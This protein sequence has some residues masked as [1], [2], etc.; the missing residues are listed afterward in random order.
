M[1]ELKDVTALVYD[2]GLFLVPLA[3]KLAEKCKH[4]YVT[5]PWETGFS[6]INAAIL[7]DGFG[8]DNI[9]RV[10][11]LW[12]V[13][14]KVDLFCFPDVQHSGEQREL[15]SQGKAVWGSRCGDRLELYRELFLKTL[16]KVGLKVPKHT[17]VVGLDNL[18]ALLKDKEDC[19]IKISKYRGTLETTHWRSWALDS[20]LLALW[21]MRMGPAGRKMRFIV[22]DKIDTPLEI[23]GD[24]YGVNGRWPKRMLHGIE[25]KDESYFAAVTETAEMPEQIQQVM[26]AFAP[27][28]GEHGY[29]NQFSMEVRVKDGVGNFI[30][31][32]CR[33]G[34]PSTAS[35]HEAWSNFA[36]I[37]WAGANGE[38][39]EP[40]LATVG[41]TGKTVQ[42]TAECL[43]TMKGDEDLWLTTEIPKELRRWMKLANVCRIDGQ[44]AFPSEQRLGD[45][46]GWLVAVGHTPEETIERMNAQ[47]DLLPDGI[48][49][50][51]ECLAYVLKE[52]HT[53]EEEGMEFGREK[54]PDPEIV[55]AEI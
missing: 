36:E 41:E 40:E 4:V 26:E 5:S 25:H 32:T 33:G 27:I 30:D 10:D 50:R 51:T 19:Y 24:T 29:A 49:A 12:D 7:G 52:I 53:E 6:T 11:S 1:K 20:D 3:Q 21:R 44:V 2:H 8:A 54:V 38:L 34:L 43:L 22:C 47:A 17:V 13:K 39:V 48:D 42:Y 55:L 14:N 18:A 35:Q 31:A 9:E 28:L 23:G 37:V 15:E 45:N 16:A 46:I